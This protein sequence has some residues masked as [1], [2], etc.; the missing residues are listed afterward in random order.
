MKKLLT[1]LLIGAFVLGLGAADIQPVSAASVKDLKEAKEKVDKAKEKVDKV[2]DKVDKAKDKFNKDDKNPPEP[3][4]DSNGNP[5]AP[6][7]RN[8]D[9]SNR[10]APPTR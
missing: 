5:M 3:P 9:D 1:G 2:K 10:P 8:N 7:D 4:K 6:P